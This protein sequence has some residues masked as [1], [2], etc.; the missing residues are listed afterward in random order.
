MAKGGY[1]KLRT[2]EVCLD[3]LTWL[4][5]N[6]LDSDSPMVSDIRCILD[7]ATFRY[8]KQGGFSIDNILIRMKE[9]GWVFE[10]DAKETQLDFNTF[11]NFVE[12]NPIHV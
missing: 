10:D 5:G 6:K 4:N 11:I 9:D 2:K 8:I 1:D 12:N 7:K 3:F